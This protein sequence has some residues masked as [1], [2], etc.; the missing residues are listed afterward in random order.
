MLDN[1]KAWLQ[2]LYST[3]IMAR[4]KVD[5]D[6]IIRKAYQVFREKGYSYT[7]MADIGQ[8]CGLQK[9]SVYYYFPSKEELM[10]Q[11]LIMDHE[12]MKKNLS[13]L[14]YSQQVPYKQ[15]LRRML[16]AIE[17]CYFDAPG[18]CL[19]AN[20]G[21]ESAQTVPAF[22]KVI[23]R[24]FEDWI[25]T[26]AY[27]FESQ[28]EKAKAQL[29]AEQAVQEIEGAVMLSVL[30]QDKRYFYATSDRILTYLN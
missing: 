2:L 29:M 17:D 13:S 5:K 9:G 20:I 10:L 26:F 24:F 11:V 4:Q 25:A 16:Q 18:G 23:K 21:L 15:R 1:L 3:P 12:N 27:I 30:F 14:A 22:T 8:A 7:S 19:M 6:F 28:Y